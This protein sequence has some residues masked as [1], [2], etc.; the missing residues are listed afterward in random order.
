MGYQVSRPLRCSLVHDELSA[1]VGLITHSELFE[2][3][4]KSVRP[5]DIHAGSK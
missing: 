4:D 5:R 2:M 1:L 3:D